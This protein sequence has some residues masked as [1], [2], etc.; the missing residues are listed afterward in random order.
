MQTVLIGQ[1]N[2]VEIINKILEDPPHIFISGG[3]GFG[4]T[5]FL[6]EFITTYFTSKNIKPS[7]ESILWLSSE[8]DRGIHCIRQS[9]AEFVKH[10]TNTPNVYRWIVIDD[11]DSLPIISQ[12]ALRRPMETHAY[13]TRF[14]FCSRYKSDL[15]PPLYSRCMHIEM[16]I[17]P[18]TNL[19]NHFIKK[20]TTKKITFSTDFM[21]ILISIFTIPTEIRNCIRILVN[22]FGDRDEYELTKND[23]ITLF[24]APSFSLCYQLLISYINNNNDEMVRI[25]LEIWKTGLSY[26]DFLHELDSSFKLIEYVPSAISQEIHELLIKGW[27]NFAQGKT[28]TLDIM[29]L[30]LRPNDKS[31]E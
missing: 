23:M 10:T 18:P 24:S 9:V 20:Y 26:E 1:E 31:Q 3:Y 6:R 14:I 8:Q 27:I 30:F 16:N 13:S 28:H 25:F 22:H 12:Q 19:I 5:T 2:N 4:K 21:N 7:H 11:A 17:I 29:R 15:I